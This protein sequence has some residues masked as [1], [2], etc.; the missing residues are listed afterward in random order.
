MFRRKAVFDKGY[1]I[2]RSMNP[3]RENVCSGRHVA[4][5]A[6]ALRLVLGE[7]W[8]YLGHVRNDAVEI[9]NANASHPALRHT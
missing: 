5:S 4:R 3:N 8:K 9:V 2:G 7:D 1:I 6:A